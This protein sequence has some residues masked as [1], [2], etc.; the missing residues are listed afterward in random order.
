MIPFGAWVIISILTGGAAGAGDLDIG[1]AAHAEHFDSPEARLENPLAK[2]RLSRTHK[3]VT[4][5]VEHTSGIF[6]YEQG[7][8]NNEIGFTIRVR[9]VGK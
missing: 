8:G 9:S 6:D 7:N 5:Y 2:F 4:V 3:R 1:L